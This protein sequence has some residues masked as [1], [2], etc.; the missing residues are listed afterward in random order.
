MCH[1]AQLWNLDGSPLPPQ[2]STL[3][4]AIFLQIFNIFLLQLF[5]EENHEILRSWRD[6]W[7][8]SPDNLGGEKEED[9]NQE[10]GR[11]QGSLGRDS[12]TIPLSVFNHG[13]G[14]ETCILLLVFLLSEDSQ[15]S[16]SFI[17]LSKWD[18]LIRNAFLYTLMCASFTSLRRRIDFKLIN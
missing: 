12:G 16:H 14:E 11:R 13:N 6:Q 3:I 8:P 1:Y 17:F 2:L 18:K 7:G 9:C 5:H 15:S 10:V 4:W